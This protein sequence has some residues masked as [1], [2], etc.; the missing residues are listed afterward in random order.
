MVQRCSVCSHDSHFEINRHLLAGVPYRALAAQYG[1]PP[2]LLQ[3]P[4]PPPFFSSA[5]VS[6]VWQDCGGSKRVN[7]PLPLATNQGRVSHG[8][9]FFISKF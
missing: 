5:P 1:L 8:P 6:W 4:S 3:S 7:Q 2:L 9:A